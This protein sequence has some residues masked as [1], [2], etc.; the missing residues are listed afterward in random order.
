MFKPYYLTWLIYVVIVSVFFI[1][2]KILNYKLNQM[3]DN[4]KITVTERP[5]KRSIKK[6]SGFVALF[7]KPKA[8]NEGNLS[9]D[10][11]SSNSRQNSNSIQT[12]DSI[13][14]Y[15]NNRR[16]IITSHISRRIH[17]NEI[18]NQYSPDINNRFEIS[19]SFLSLKEGQIPPPPPV[20][21]NQSSVINH[22][23][24]DDN[25]G[26]LFGTADSSMIDNQNSKL[27]PP[28]ALASKKDTT[29]AVSNRSLFKISEESLT[30]TSSDNKYKSDYN[31]YFNDEDED[32]QTYVDINL[33]M[34]SSNINE[35][36]PNEVNTSPRN[37]TSIAHYNQLKMFLETKQ[38]HH[39]HSDTVVRLNEVSRSNRMLA[40]ASRIGTAFGNLRSSSLTRNRHN[41]N[42][43]NESN[44]NLSQSAGAILRSMRRDLFHRFSSGSSGTYMLPPL[45]LPPH[46]NARPLPTVYQHHHGSKMASQSQPRTSKSLLTNNYETVNT[47]NDSRGGVEIIDDKFYSI[48]GN[49][50]DNGDNKSAELPKLSISAS[51]LSL[52]KIKVNKSELTN[53]STS[54]LCNISKND[55]NDKLR[56]SNSIPKLKKKSKKRKRDADA[57]TNDHYEE[58]EIINDESFDLVKKSLTKPRPLAITKGKDVKN[59][60]DSVYLD[61]D[62]NSSNNSSLD[63]K[64]IDQFIR[65]TQLYQ[66]SSSSSSSSNSSDENLNDNNSNRRQYLLKE[67]D[68]IQILNDKEE[69]RGDNDNES[70]KLINPPATTLFSDEDANKWENVIQKFSRFQVTKKYSINIPFSHYSLLTMLDR[71]K[72]IYE[73]IMTCLLATMVSALA[74]LIIKENVYQDFTL[75]AFCFIVSSCQ[76]SLI[77]SVQPDSSSPIH[78]FNRLTPLSRPIFFCIFTSSILLIRFLISLSSNDV[79]TLDSINNNGSSLNQ[80]R[81]PFSVY[82]ISITKDHLNCSLYILEILTLC[83]P[84]LF[85]LG[86]FPQVNTFLICL[87]EQADMHLFGGTAM[88]HLSGA[89]INCLRSVVTVIALGAIL[90]SSIYNVDSTEN[91]TGHYISKLLP[92]SLI[93]SV[94]CGLIVL[95][96][97]IYSRQSS[98]TNIY[99]KLIKNFYKWNENKVK[100]IK[101]NKKRKKRNR[102]QQK[103]NIKTSIE[104]QNLKTKNEPS[105]NSK[106]VIIFRVTNML[107]SI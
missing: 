23:N 92:Q 45:P 37:D 104:M 12:T 77:K 22:S 33:P 62:M 82:G 38:Q 78:G 55:N 67:N 34:I 7:M 97:Y 48:I 13:S 2:L 32:D 27:T 19:A 95:I 94:Y 68:E 102:K 18:E 74:A 49:T 30:V 16:P 73:L 11:N 75:M 65:N 105:P 56:K 8:S 57:T 4:N 71:N 63:N 93:F 61:D 54:S 20:P 25:E 5:I 31:K 24:D 1:L 28:F 59:H 26:D 42:N 58:I 44:R 106:K 89:V 85:T 41:S 70:I 9:F 69:K 87:L 29:E 17:R 64:E 46:F 51:N 66:N 21:Q 14:N 72:T 81:E 35:S 15:Q 86:L 80:T 47:D 50:E 52:D 88:N 39:Q 90:L 107:Y 36:N 3:F 53:L 6:S 96:S 98:E 43:E 76:Y 83:L 101:K 99:F 103:N 60:P 79:D 100:T 40:A 91:N 10:L 84:L